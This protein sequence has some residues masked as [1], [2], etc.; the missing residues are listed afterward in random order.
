M[1]PTSSQGKYRGRRM[2]Q[3]AVR[4]RDP[5]LPDT[6]VPTTHT[7]KFKATVVWER[8]STT[9]TK[10]RNTIQ[11][12]LDCATVIIDGRHVKI[13]FRNCFFSVTFVAGN[14]FL[15]NLKW[16]SGFHVAKVFVCL[17]KLV[18]AVEKLKWDIFYM[19]DFSKHMIILIEIVFRF[20]KRI[21]FTQ[22]AFIFPGFDTITLRYLRHL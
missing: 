16:S 18:T 1:L 13:G 20:I 9:W 11:W 5:S 12:I 19:M 17:S 21:R 4:R 15:V 14:G 2:R 3:T 10:A 22:D 7:N 6:E 8:C